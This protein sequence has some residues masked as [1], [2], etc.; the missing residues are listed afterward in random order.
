MR[1][2]A[3]AVLVLTALLPLSAT[4]ATITV[5]SGETLSDIAERYGVSLTT[6]MRLNGI[7]NP[8]HVEIG[9]R[10]QVPGPRVS[11]GKGRHR[12]TS[13][14]NLS[15]IAKEYRVTERELMAVNGLSNPNHVEV[16]QTLKLPSNAVMAKPAFKPVAVKPI[17][18]ATEHTVA[19][20]QT[21]TQVAKAYRI[22]VATLI[23]INQITNPNKVEVGT[24]LYLTTSTPVEQ[25]AAMVVTRP[26]TATA[27][28]VATVDV[29]PAKVQTATVETA[30]VQTARVQPARVTTAQPKPAAAK[31]VKAV[32]A[33]SADWRN[34]G[35]LQVDW[36]N[37][38][39]MGGSQVVPTLNAKGQ[40]L[41]VAV[42]CSAGKIN[43]TG[44]D[45]S[46]KAWAAPQTSF[47][48][49]LL[50]DRCTAKA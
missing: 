36:A 6:L 43:A 2:T 3:L 10:L 32:V 5:K 23:S 17:P 19:K 41:Y 33:K 42:N 47:E 9:S 28:K 45:G 22:P 18:G 49:D 16:G 38:R 25:R 12:V 40:A 34:Y 50:K 24:R 1:R 7:R 15:S 14:E 48:K 4:A 37:W 44:A 39:P 31:P 27:T 21:L 13:G 35:P 30:P 8:N 26:A 20:G 29:Q 11:A 46:W